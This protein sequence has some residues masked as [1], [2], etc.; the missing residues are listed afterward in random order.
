MVEDVT[1]YVKALI[2]KGIQAG[3]SDIHFEPTMEGIVVRFRLDG[4]L[5]VIETKEEGWGPPTVSRIKLM[6]GMD[7]GER[8]L[9]QDGGFTFQIGEATEERSIDVRVATLPTIYGEKIVLR[10]LPHETRYQSLGSLGMSGENVFEIRKMLARSQ[11]MILIAGP[12][13]SGKT[14]TM[15]TML[16][17][18]QR[19]GRNIVSLE[20]PVEYRIPG[21]NQVQIH[22]RTGLSFHEGLR[23]VLRQDPDVILVGEIRDKP[24]AEVAVRAALTGHL[25]LSTI[26]TLDAVGTVLRLLDMGIDPYLVNSALTGVV[27]Q[28]LIRKRCRQCYGQKD[29]SVCH[30][31]GFHGRVGI[32]EVL[33]IE[34]EL[35]PYI[36]NR[37]SATTLR[38]HLQKK[39]FTF[40]SSLL[41]KKI[42][43]GVAESIEQGHY[44]MHVE[45]DA[46]VR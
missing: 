30:N 31:T 24:T 32:Y 8:R 17:E 7:I 37:C 34:E 15:Y 36:L 25:L 35:H 28:R 5:R 13:G 42:T 3:A 20:Q 6:S 16:H 4:Y 10:L 23:A 14:T 38:R 26:H 46:M 21:I 9:P 11:G 1:G 33:E 29:C 39:G 43:E 40:L 12:T 18:L 2:R 45:G 41:E 44:A 27:A 22:P 19:H